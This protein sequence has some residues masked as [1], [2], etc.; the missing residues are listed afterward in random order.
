[1]VGLVVLVVDFFL[2]VSVVALPLLSL[3]PRQPP[4]GPPKPPPGPPKAPPE[5]SDGLLSDGLPTTD[6]DERP[7][8]FL[9]FS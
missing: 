3:L 4:P 1:M 7:Y 6:P 2:V 5:P 9:G 8:D